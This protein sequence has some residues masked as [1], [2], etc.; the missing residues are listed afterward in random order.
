MEFVTPQTAKNILRNHARE[1]LK[2]TPS[3]DQFITKANMMCALNNDKLVPHLNRLYAPYSV[4]TT[5]AKEDM[6]FGANVIRFSESEYGWQ[7]AFHNHG[8]HMRRGRVRAYE[9]REEMVRMYGHALERYYQRAAELRWPEVLRELRE[10]HNHVYQWLRFAK[11][12]EGMSFVL[13][14]AGGYYVGQVTH[15]ESAIPNEVAARF[16]I[17]TFMK[18]G[19]PRY[20]RVKERYL[21]IRK[22]ASSLKGLSSVDARHELI[23][24]GLSQIINDEPWLLEPYE[25]SQI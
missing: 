9:V 23:V 8:M 20:D 1:V 12:H 11:Q 22:A 18:D 10:A 5:Y 15:A 19:T 25:D 2:S 13:P 14:T 7:I 21:A 24:Q 6:Y 16:I 17:K 4:V 3:D